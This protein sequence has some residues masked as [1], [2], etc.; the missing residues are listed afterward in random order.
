MNKRIRKKKEKRVLMEYS[1]ALVPV[2]PFKK[3]KQ[4][5]NEQWKMYHNAGYKMNIGYKRQSL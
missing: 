3:R 1:F 2:Y 4:I 5:V